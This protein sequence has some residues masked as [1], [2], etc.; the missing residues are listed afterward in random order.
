MAS[1]KPAAPVV[2]LA[3]GG[4]A[5]MSKNERIK[6]ASQGL[7][8]VQPAKG[9]RHAFADELDALER[10][11][12]E[13]ISG[14]AKEISKFFGIYKQ[15]ARGERGKKVDDYFFMVRI[16]AP[17]GGGFSRNQW[18]ALDRAAD[19]Y[20]DG[21]LRVTSRQGIQYHHVYGPKLASLIR[22]LNRSYRDGATLGACGDVNRN[23]MGCPIEGLDPVYATGAFDLSCEIAD[24]LAP[25]TTAYFQIF[26]SDAEGRTLRPINPAEP[27]Y[28]ETY[29]PRKFKIGIAHP[30]DNSI[31]VL[32]QDVGLVPVTANG[33]IDG[34]VWDLY[35][36]GG[37]G[38]TH[39]MPQTAALLGL[40]LGRVRREQVVEVCKSIAILQREQ[41]ERKDRRQARWKYTIRRLG[42]DAVQ[43]ML[44]DRFRI[45]LEAAE[46]APLPPMQLHLGWHEQR[47]GGGYYGISV[48]NGRVTPALRAAIRRAV[49]E[50]NLSVRAT[51]QQDLLLCDVRDRAAL[52]RILEQG[53]VAK[54][55]SISI[56]RR[57]SM[58]CP[59]KPTCGLAMTDAEGILPSYMDAIEA[60]G[61][62]DVDVVI[63]MTGCPNN[64]ARPPSAEI[65]IYG[66][67]KNDHV[68]LVGGS[69]EGTR[70]AQPLYARLPGEQMIPA[71][72]GL[73]TA[74][75]D[76]AKGRPA[77]EFLHET[78][79]EQLRRWIGV[80]DEA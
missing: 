13:T 69:R 15:Q 14:E 59:A 31:D 44:R 75:R 3:G 54:P 37:L 58:A 41:G 26:Q 61:L 19:A 60:A 43:K 45:E 40:Y 79:P 53:G 20:A 80:S 36:G 32:T 17:A 39:N 64:C 46:P 29:L 63:R 56:V 73:L 77:G 9:E 47:G 62:G 49:E 57:N 11:E 16:K 72:V 1:E 51:A 55:E 21:T 23:V 71:L 2:N 28:G 6:A 78:D 27:V 76:R 33:V 4:L 34:S 7:F 50:L 48:E 35:S 12:S 5:Q 25:K 18:L 38:L 10:G 65:G 74:I 42:I 66:Y 22:H 67:G 8:Y 24:E 30:T 70:I 52:E 68:V